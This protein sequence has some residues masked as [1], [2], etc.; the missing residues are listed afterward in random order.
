MA[1]LKEL[2]GFERAEGL[3]DKVQGACW[4]LAETILTEAD[5]VENHADR[6]AWSLRVLRANSVE[7]MVILEMLRAVVTVRD[8]SDI[9]DEDIESTVAAVVGLFAKSGV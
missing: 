6:I 1:T 2:V 3:K 4:R 9:S 5:S 7:S 8:S